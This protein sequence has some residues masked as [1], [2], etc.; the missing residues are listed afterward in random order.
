LSNL[1]NIL[2]GSVVHT[3]CPS[4]NDLLLATRLM[5]EVALSY[6]LPWSSALS[7]EVASTITVEADDA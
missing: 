3:T 4:S 5:V 2:H 6:V 1:R 7:R